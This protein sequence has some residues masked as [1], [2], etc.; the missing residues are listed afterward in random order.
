MQPP[1]PEGSPGPLPI[2]SLPHQSQQRFVLLPETPSTPA[3]SPSLAVPE[4]PES[5]S[6]QRG[7]HGWSTQLSI[8]EPNYIP[9]T[10]AL[11]P[12]GG[13]ITAADIRSLSAA[14]RQRFAVHG[15][16]GPR[17]WALGR[18]TTNKTI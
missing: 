16:A 4:T 2:S 15:T 17:N 13:G 18:L 11:T 14:A 1:S 6:I 9:T 5:V 7:T 10:P 3:E 8:S 12:G